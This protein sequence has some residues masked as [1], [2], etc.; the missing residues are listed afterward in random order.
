M[1][2]VLGIKE[3]PATHNI[4]MDF[5]EKGQQLQGVKLKSQQSVDHA[6]TEQV[7]ID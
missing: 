2:K 4:L 1:R 3:P 7:V 5:L 6:K